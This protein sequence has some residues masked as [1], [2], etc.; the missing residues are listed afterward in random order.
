MLLNSVSTKLI[1][2]IFSTQRH[3]E[4]K[5]TKREFFIFY[6]SLC[7]C[8]LCVFVLKIPSL[9]QSSQLTGR[10]TDSANSVIIK[11]NITLINTDNGRSYN[12]TSNGEGYFTIPL[13]MPGIYQITV[14]KEGFRPITRSGIVL[15]VDQFARM[16]IVLEPGLMTEAIQISNN[17]PLLKTE[18]SSLGQV[19][20]GRTMRDLPLNGRNYLQ[21]AKLTSGVVE[22]ASN[23]RASSGGAFVANGVRSQLNNFI[24]DGVDNNSRILDFQNSSNLVVQPSIDALAEFKVQTHN[25]SAEYGHSAGA[26]INVVTKSGT[27]KYHGTLFEYHRNSVF[28]ARHFFS[29]PKEKKPL[30]IRNQFGG[31]IGGPI[32]SN[33]TF[34]F[35]SYEGTREHRGVTYLRTVPTEALRNGNFGSTPIYDPLTT[36]RLPNG[37]YT[38]TQFLN[39][40]IPKE[41]FDPVAVKLMALLP[42]PNLP[43]SINNYSITRNQSVARNQYDFRLDH[44]LTRNNNLFGRFSMGE[45]DSM[46]PGPYLPPLVGSPDF[47]TSKKDQGARA[48]AIGDTYIFRNNTVNEFRVGYNRIGDY[49]NPFVNERISEQF[50]FK[51]IPNEANITGLPMIGISGYGTMGEASFIPNYKISETVH[52]NDNVTLV[53]GSHTLKFGA[54]Y[55]FVRSFFNVSG[56]ARGDFRFNGSMTQDPRP[57]KRPGTGSGWADFLLGTTSSASLSTMFIGDLRYRYWGFYLQD[58][59]KVRPNLTLNIG[60][61]YDYSSPQYERNN[62]QANFLVEEGKLIFPYNKVP[63]GIPDSMV[64]KIPNGV[65]QRALIKPDKN[66]FGPRIGLAWQIGSAMLLR[67]GVGVF[68]ADHAAIGASGRLLANPPFRYDK[69]FQSD[70]LFSELKLSDGFPENTLNSVNMNTMTA[71]MSFSTDFPQAYTYHW[72][73]NLQRELKGFMFEAGYAGT[74]GVQLPVGNFDVNQPIP[75]PG[76]PMS[77]RPIKGLA[78]INRHQP[79]GTS[80]Y[81]SFL[82]TGERRFS[83]GFRLLTSYTY[84][85][86]IDIGGE[87]LLGDLNPRNTRLLHLER[88]LSSFDMRHRFVTSYTWE[89]PF[90]H[91]KRFQLNSPPLNAIFG[92]WQIN[93]ITTIRSGTPFTPTTNSAETGSRPD[94]IGYGSLPRSERTV[95]KYF[96]PSAFL[97]PAQYT[98]GN[99]GKNILIGP[100]AVNFDFS[101]F[102]NFRTRILGDE[103]LVQF[104]AEAF[105]I[106]N[107][108]QF[109]NPNTRI[110]PDPDPNRKGQYLGG[111]ITSLRNTMREFQF[112]LKVIF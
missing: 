53:R 71:L 98:Y 7:L 104:R 15:Q 4:H 21:L 60:L 103:G 49:L 6:S 108:P 26:V 81:H 106:L 42:L 43:G 44:R 111:S 39:N 90:G 19:I 25:F 35:G 99:A 23:D 57:N 87:Q 86:S 18:S 59:W 72:N 84:S 41:R 48:I 100:G 110:D 31:T 91:N 63:A 56:T 24:L 51:G 9:A 67:S 76:T 13:L 55:R 78:A 16:D 66:N 12:S 37:T 50:G 79:M 61:R 10:I 75:G 93:G 68:F 83:R 58:D 109:G 28:D 70:V 54:E 47:Q 95:D 30:L 74:G 107:T 69:V 40:A 29:N 52:L 88:S 73:L 20:D 94:R 46:T 101:L 92:N 64:T 8:V 45:L 2:K 33:R 112:G 32:V 36:K 89:L 96:D 97:P 85:K 34:F 5:D 3:K 22:S 38:R 82:V 77:R 14:I 105:N 11:A 102:K 62:R 80:R 65:D 1:L 27:N 17:E